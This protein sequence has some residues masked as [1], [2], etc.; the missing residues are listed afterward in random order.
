MHMENLLS[1]LEK[2]PL[3]E[4][5]SAEIIAAN[6]YKLIEP[7]LKKGITTEQEELDF[8][9]MVDVALDENGLTNDAARIEALNHIYKATGF[10]YFLKD[11]ASPKAPLRRGFCCL[12]AKKKDMFSSILSL[13]FHPYCASCDSHQTYL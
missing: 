10:P 1:I 11:K 13:L 4:G 6:L 12:R 8:C 2:A 7:T 3:E 9:N 5:V